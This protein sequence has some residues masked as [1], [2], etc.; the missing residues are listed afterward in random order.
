MASQL[1]F[2][3]LSL[4]PCF[5]SVIHAEV[6]GFPN[7]LSEKLMSCFIGLAKKFTQV[8]P[9]GVTEKL[10]HFIRRY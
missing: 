9:L 3:K 6:P 5:W 7:I 10:P 8:F 2:S 1:L 4:F